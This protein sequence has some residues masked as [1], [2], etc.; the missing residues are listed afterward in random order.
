M[1]EV[2][3]NRGKLQHAQLFQEAVEEA[4]AFQMLLTGDEASTGFAAAAAQRAAVTAATVNSMP[5]CRKC[6][7]CVNLASSGRR[8]CLLVRAFAAASAGHPG[9]VRHSL[10]YFVAY[11]LWLCSMFACAYKNAANTHGTRLQMSSS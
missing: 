2:A 1:A 4:Q 11:W 7:T 5:R 3:R 10:L 8:R 6:E 9:N